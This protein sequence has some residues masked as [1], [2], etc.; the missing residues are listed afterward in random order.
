[1][2][3]IISINKLNNNHKIKINDN[4]AKIDNIN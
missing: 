1:M 3:D 2:K 4:N